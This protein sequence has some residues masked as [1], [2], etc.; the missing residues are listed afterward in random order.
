[1][2]SARIIGIL[3]A[4]GS[5][6]RFGGKKLDALLGG[7]MIG[8][9]AARALAACRCGWFAAVCGDDNSALAGMLDQLGFVT[10]VN[11][12]PEAGLSHSLV[13]GARQASQCDADAMLVCLGDMPF[14]TSDHLDR[15]I[16]AFA[17]AD[18]QACITS[19]YGQTR[20]PPAIFPKSRFPE[21]MALAGDQGARLL[22]RDA[23]GVAT[24]P[25]LLA[26]IDTQDDLA[27]HN[28]TA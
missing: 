11:A 19:Q 10:I 7:M 18:G 26:D 12:N 21:L 8:E 14:V 17:S 6:S 25:L 13:L 1:M 16:A 23:I 5:G 2:A 15:L 9:H 4:A 27:A 20:T 28:G 22:L 3:L 24:D